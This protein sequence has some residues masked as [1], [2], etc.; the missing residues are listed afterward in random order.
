TF[1]GYRREE[2]FDKV[3][4]GRGSRREVQLEAGMLGEPGLHFL[5]LMGR[6]VVDD[7]MKVEGLRH[8]PV[9]LFEEANGLVGA[10]ARQAFS[11]QLAGLD[12]KSGKESRG[13]VAL[14]V[15]RH[16]AGTTLLQGQARLGAVESLDLRFFVDRQ[17]Q[18]LI[19]WVE[20]E[21]NNIP[22]L[23]GEMRIVRE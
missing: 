3:D 11:K 4:P 15:V 6:V 10:W 9:D 8:H 2:A 5:G 12:I 18:C 13:A 16:R 20:I 17:H 21:T 14:I 23:F 7:E 19:G 22:H 1:A